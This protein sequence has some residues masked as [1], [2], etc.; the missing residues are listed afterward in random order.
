MYNNRLRPMIHGLLKVDARSCTSHEVFV[1]G[2]L[3]RNDNPVD[4]IKTDTAVVVDVTGFLKSSL[5]V[6]L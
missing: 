4:A 3:P 2:R 1:F 5:K 6:G